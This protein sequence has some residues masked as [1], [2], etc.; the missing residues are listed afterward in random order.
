ME[1]QTKFKLYEE[2]GFWKDIKH[3]FREYKKTVGDNTENWISSYVHHGNDVDEFM[4]EAFTL[5]YMR[6]KGLPVPDQ[7]GDDTVFSSR[8]LEI[9]RKYFGK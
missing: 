3:T 5:A 2:S 8:V 7:Y 9:V 6:E 1:R 4:A